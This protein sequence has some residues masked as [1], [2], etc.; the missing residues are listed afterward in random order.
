MH[1]EVY[2]EEYLSTRHWKWYFKKGG[3]KYDILITGNF[4]TRDEAIANAKSCILAI[5]KELHLPD[6]IKFE[7]VVINPDR[8]VIRW[9]IDQ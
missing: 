7:T 1:I 8:K 2:C 3:S 6:K 5:F 9:K 4:A